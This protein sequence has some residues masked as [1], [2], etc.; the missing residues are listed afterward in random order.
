MF[1]RVAYC[2]TSLPSTALRYHACQAF[3]ADGAIASQ[4][5]EILQR[6]V[7]AARVE[8]ILKKLINHPV[9]PSGQ[10]GRLAE[11]IQ[12]TEVLRSE[13]ATQAKSDRFVRT[14]GGRQIAL[15]PEERNHSG[16]AMSRFL[17]GTSVDI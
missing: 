16:R 15:A 1:L 5:E 17:Y 6:A 8:L 7:S 9:D 3:R 11:I 12:A 13:L 4:P 2:A 14:L 10:S